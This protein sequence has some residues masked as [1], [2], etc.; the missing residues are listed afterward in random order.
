MKKEVNMLYYKILFL[1]IFVKYL[2]KVYE[3]KK[4]TKN[5][6]VKKNIIQN[7]YY[8][9]LFNYIGLFIITK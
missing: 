2:Q 3:N 9:F 7:R 4:V 1:V 8:L 5:I 6:N